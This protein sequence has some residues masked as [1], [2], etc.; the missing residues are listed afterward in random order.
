MN[1]LCKIFGHK[2]YFDS[3]D[4]GGPTT[5]KRCDHKEPA[6]KLAYTIA[7]PKVRSPKIHKE[8]PNPRPKPR[9]RQEA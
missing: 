8:P 7:M 4:I 5:C 9:R 2:M 6:I 3:F 1:I